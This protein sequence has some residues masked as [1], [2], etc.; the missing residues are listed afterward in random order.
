LEI[1][2]V[3]ASPAGDT[4]FPPIDSKMWRETARM[5]QEAA[6]DDDADVSFIT[7]ERAL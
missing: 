2:L 3:H 7:Y 4:F 5:R 6:P 1:T